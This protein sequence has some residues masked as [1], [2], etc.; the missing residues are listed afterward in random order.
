[1]SATYARWK[2]ALDRAGGAWPR[3][4]VDLDA[5]RENVR[6]LL[7]PVRAAKKSLRLATKSLRCPE[8]VDFVRAEAPEVF[9]GLMTYAPL[10]AAFWVDRGEK[11]VYLAYP[12]L[13]PDA[14]RLIARKNEAAVLAVAVDCVEQIDAADRAGR[15]EGVPIP[16]VVDVDMS[17]R[18]LGGR[19][20]LGVLRSPVRSADAVVALA[21]DV[22][23][24]KGVRFHG[25][26]GYEAQIAGLGDAQPDGAAK[27]LVRRA[28]R[29]VSKPHVRQLR[30]EVV[31]ALRRAGLPPAL[32]NGGGTGSLDSSSTEDVLT[33]VTAGSG[34]V[35]SHLFDNYRH[36]ELVP[37]LAFALEVVRTP[38]PGVVTCAGGG[39]IASGG[40]GPDKLPRPY[41]PEGLTLTELEGAGEVQTPLHVPP[42]T[43]IRLGDPVFFRPAK[44]GELAER[45]DRYFA[46]GAGVDRDFPTYRS[47]GGW[48]M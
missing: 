11:D 29:S 46:F 40:A 39:Y 36:F 43:A 19:A 24:R 41:L 17:Y 12:T 13:R 3:A 33:E 4:L 10:E 26:M 37:A 18:P 21:R 25:V 9:H 48:A 16:V 5:V 1:M 22:A 7:P 20:H 14:L 28:V 8:L 31:E 38:G 42:R 23:A 27:N 15:D 35:D 32:V 34:F 45:F 47:L 2:A 30:R 6:R 44:A